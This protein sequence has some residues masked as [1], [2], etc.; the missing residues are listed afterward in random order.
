MVPT[1]SRC[2]RTDVRTGPPARRLGTHLRL[3]T[4][5]ALLVLLGLSGIGGTYA[6][7]NEQADL[8]GPTIE[9]GTSSLTVTWHGGIEQPRSSNLLPGE[10]VRQRA[11]VRNTG[12]AALSLAGLLPAPTPGLELRVVGGAAQDPLTAPMLG[13]TAQPI[14]TS[15]TSGAA[16]I[17]PPGGSADVTVE[18]RATGALAPGADVG[19]DI[20]IEGKQI[21]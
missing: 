10:S 16:L 11:T 18:H 9:S 13:G 19:F 20:V 21:P 12:D 7:W 14:S 15:A 5:A 4:A 1:D 6:M 17:L 3:S 8:A 2:S